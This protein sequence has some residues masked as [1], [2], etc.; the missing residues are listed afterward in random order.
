MGHHHCLQN[1]VR[2]ALFFLYSLYNNIQNSDIAACHM[3]MLMVSGIQSVLE[4]DTVILLLKM[5]CCI[6][7]KSR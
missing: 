3:I 4:I 7:N 1:T 2:N 5:L 6:S